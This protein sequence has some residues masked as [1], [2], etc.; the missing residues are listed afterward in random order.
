MSLIRVPAVVTLLLMLPVL[1]FAEEGGLA[2]KGKGRGKGD[3]LD[4]AC[5][6]SAVRARDDAIIA[7]HDALHASLK[8][9]FETRRDALVAAWGMAD[10]AQRK[11]ALREAWAAFKTSRKDAVK[12]LRDAKRSAWQTFKNSFRSCK[13]LE[14][15]E[16]AP[17]NSGEGVDNA[18][19]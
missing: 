1:A 6:Q 8:A 11:S 10:K 3:S 7:A 9:A 5:V 17:E 14:S 13:G 12:T 4:T 15:S 2:G 16:A 18:A 19:M